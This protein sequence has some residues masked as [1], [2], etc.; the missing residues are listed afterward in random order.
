MEGDARKEQNKGLSEK[1]Q[2]KEVVYWIRSGLSF[3]C[4]L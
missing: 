1:F 4:S 2:G 3:N